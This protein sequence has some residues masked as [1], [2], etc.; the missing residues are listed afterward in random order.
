[1]TV[2]DDARKTYEEWVRCKL[3]YNVNIPPDQFLWRGRT[4][5]KCREAK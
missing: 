2:E 1:M 5:K 3:I 4:C